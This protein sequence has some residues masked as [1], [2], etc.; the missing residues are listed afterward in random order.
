MSKENT[1]IQELLR[2]LANK[3]EFTLLAPN[4]PATCHKF[5]GDGSDRQFFRCTNSTDDSFVIILPSTTHPE[6]FS[7][8]KASYA[9]G[10]HLYMMGLPIPKLY[11]FDELSGALIF[12]DLGDVLLFDR[13]DK[14]STPALISLYRQTL[15]CL[16]EFQIK[17]RQKFNLNWCWDTKHYDEQLMLDRESHYFSLE[18]C[19][20]YL[21]IPLQTDMEEDF[22]RLASRISQEPADFLLHR[23]FQS[24]N[25]MF[26]NG[27]P[28]IIDFQG[29]RLGP[30]GYDLASLLNDPYI[31]LDESTKEELIIF[32]VKEI[33]NFTPLDYNKF[34]S[35]Y[36]HIA[37]QRN[38]QIL[39]AFAYLTLAKKKVFFEQFIIPASNNLYFLLNKKLSSSYPGLQEL[40]HE[41]LNKL[42]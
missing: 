5:A 19:K 41:I 9:I 34:I 21:Q 17:G 33:N 4:Q 15:K 36:Y 23:D 38:L 29:A 39:G 3:E 8:A 31:Q 40:S 25:I 12:E 32:Y 22:L 30:L 6:A 18:F 7:E 16:A 1:I 2:T 26:T 37:L 28:R 20:N 24:R 11:F 27:K 35:G 13:A 14:S 10:N 42:V